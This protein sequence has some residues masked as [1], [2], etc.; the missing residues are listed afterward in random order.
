MISAVDAQNAVSGLIYANGGSIMSMM[1]GR[2]R[3]F[4]NASSAILELV[5][6]YA[7]VNDVQMAYVLSRRISKHATVKSRMYVVV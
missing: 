5:D 2:H 4:S 3:Y 6:A 7:Q 1:T